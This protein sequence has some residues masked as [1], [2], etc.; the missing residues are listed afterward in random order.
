M[1]HKCLLRDISLSG[2]KVITSGDKI[3]Y[4][5]KDVLLVIQASD[6]QLLGKIPGKVKRCEEIK[7]QKEFVVLAIQHIDGQVPA[8]YS[9][10]IIDYMTKHSVTISSK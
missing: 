10:R 2:A 4:L 9:K 6:D 5:D 1:N 8:K 7:G 3:E